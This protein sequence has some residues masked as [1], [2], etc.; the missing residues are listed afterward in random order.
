MILHVIFR[1]RTGG[2][3]KQLVNILTLHEESY[4][5]ILDSSK[6][7]YLPEI[8]DK[9]LTP[10]E[11]LKL[12]PVVVV[13]WLYNVVA[14]SEIMARLY[15]IEHVLNVRQAELGSGF[16]YVLAKKISKKRFVFYNSIL[17]KNNHLN[18]GWGRGSYV[19]KN[20]FSRMNLKSR[21]GRSGMKILGQMGRNDA[22]KRHDLFVEVSQ[23][24][25]NYKFVLAGPGV[26]KEFSKHESENLEV[27]D[28]MR[29]Q[30]FFE[31]I[32]VLL[33]LSKSEGFAN[34]IGEAIL[35]GV[36]VIGMHNCIDSRIQRFN[37]VK[38]IH[39]INEL[40]LALNQ[41]KSLSALEIKE[42]SE[43]F[44]REF[45]ISVSTTEYINKIK[46]CVV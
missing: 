25:T 10:L 36:P 17:G 23:E 44:Y 18:D 7:D 31:K 16:L 32:D 24:F 3:E 6:C 39:A 38:S 12:R 28:K 35:S 29:T 30:D 1:L 26:Y 27:N 45:S 8:A 37:S 9:I 5:F 40:S 43:E 21:N 33:V 46:E 11:L 14:I 41:L 34:V 13:S 4:V 22:I 42:I 15:R 20:G 19:V 2:A